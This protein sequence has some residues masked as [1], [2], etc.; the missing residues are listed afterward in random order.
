M[1]ARMVAAGCFLVVAVLPLESVEAQE[2][3]EPDEFKCGV[4]ALY[5][6]LRLEGKAPT[7][8]DLDRAL[9]PSADGGHSFAD[10]QAASERFG[11][12]LQGIRHDKGRIADGPAIFFLK[13]GRHGHF[14][15]T[16]PIG[17]SGKLAQVFDGVNAEPEVL[18]IAALTATQDW[19]GL[20]LI[21]T[22]N[23]LPARVGSLLLVGSLGLLAIKPMAWWRDRWRRRAL[24]APLAEG[25]RAL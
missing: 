3:A 21:P 22:P 14:L 15:V 12:A 4:L 23:R 1:I 16:R 11:L 17:H 25:S 18:D 19:T 5:S 20:A 24:F 2:T 8:A 10:L 13:R 7:L 6:L 9:P